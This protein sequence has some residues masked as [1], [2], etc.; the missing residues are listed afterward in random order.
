MPVKSENFWTDS[1][2]AAERLVGTVILYDDIPVYVENVRDGMDFAD[3][4]HRVSIVFCN[5]T[6]RTSQRKHMNSPLFKKYRDLP[7]IG[8]TNLHSKSRPAWGTSVFIRRRSSITRLHGLATTNT[9]VL[10]FNRDS[11]NIS[12]SLQNL[13]SGAFNELIYDKGFVDTHSNVFPTLDEILAKIKQKTSIAYSRKY[14]VH[15]D[16]SGVKWLY[17]EAECIGLFSGKSLSLFPKASFYRE[18]IMSDP[19][20]T[21]NQILEI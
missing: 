12:G 20:F 10:Y 18:E 1:Q 3:N 2:Q 5:D 13:P 14:C 6:S 8:W 17:R 9:E 11:E 15:M 16:S 21:L 7:K 19:L 4:K